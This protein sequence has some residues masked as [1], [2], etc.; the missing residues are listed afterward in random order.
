MM[1]RWRRELDQLQQAAEQA[2]NRYVK[3]RTRHNLE[4]EGFNNEARMLRGQLK[5]LEQTAKK[6]GLDTGIDTDAG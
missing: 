5:K 2:K 3:L 1:L 6:M 4:M